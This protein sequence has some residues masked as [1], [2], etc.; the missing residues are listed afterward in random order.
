MQCS[1]IA[2]INGASEWLFILTGASCALTYTLASLLRQLV[3][4]HI[5]KKKP[6]WARDN[7]PG[8]KGSG[9]S[10]TITVAITLVALYMYKK[11]LAL[12]FSN[13]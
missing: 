5:F 11:N 10:L 6:V 9:N 1:T 13:S 3:N 12:F 7:G 8:P 2:E 4:Y